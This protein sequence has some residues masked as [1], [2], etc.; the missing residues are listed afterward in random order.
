MSGAARSF[1]NHMRPNRGVFRACLQKALSLKA[2]L[3]KVWDDF[4]AENDF[5][6]LKRLLCLKIRHRALKKSES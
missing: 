3:G 6:Q 5:F 2:A 1:P 4:G